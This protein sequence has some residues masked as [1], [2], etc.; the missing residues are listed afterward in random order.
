MAE[1][2]Q[3]E[4]PSHTVKS[5]GYV[6]LEQDCRRPLGMDGF[7]SKLDFSEIVVYATASSEES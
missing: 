7:A 2:L 6:I 1:Q 5:L 3:Q 4:G